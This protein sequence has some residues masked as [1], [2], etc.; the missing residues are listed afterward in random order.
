MA[1][2]AGRLA[3]DITMAKPVAVAVVVVVIS[4]LGLG[5][6]AWGESPP[7]RVKYQSNPLLA[8]ET[9]TPKVLLVLSKE[10]KMFGQG[11]PGLT[12][13]DGDGRVD[14][15]FN[16]LVEYV[17]YFDSRSCYA[18]K[19][20]TQAGVNGVFM[21]GDRN[22]YFVRVGDTI[23]DQSEQAIKNSRPRGLKSYVISPRSVAGVCSNLSRSVTY[24]GQ[25]TFSGNWLNH[26]AASRMDAIRRVLYGG[27]RKVDTAFRTVLEHSFVPPDANAWGA[28]VRSDDTWLMVTPNSAYYDIRKYSPY[29][30][31]KSGTSHFF[32]RSSDLGRGNEYFPAM[33]VLLD[34]TGSY[35]NVKGKDSVNM[36]VAHT[37]P[38]PRYWDWV[39]VNRPLPDDMVLTQSARKKVLVYNLSVE[40]CVKNDFSAT[41]GCQAY[42][43]LTGTPAGEVYKPVG[44]LQRY[45]GGGKPIN[46]G[47]LTGGYNS[48]IRDAGGKLR[49][50]V[51]PVNGLPG[52]PN[53]Q[54]VPP[55]NTMTGQ[56][57]K[58][59]II[60]NIDNLRISGRPT[61]KDPASWDGQRYYNV[62]SWGNPVAEMLFE[63]VRYL[64]GLNNPSYEY[65]RQ[66]DTDEA[67]SPI[68][69]LTDF[70]SGGSAWAQRR[71]DLGNTRCSKSI[72][73]LISDPTTEKDGDQFQNDL[74]LNLMP[75]ITLPGHFSEAN[76]LPKKFDK[77]VY[78][79]TI[80]KIEG[81]NGQ[82]NYIYS[83][84]AT[85]TC[86]PKALWSLK[87]VK[88]QCPFSPSTE[89]TYAV[90][91]VAYYA[92]AHNFGSGQG[93][94]GTNLDVYTVTMS[95]PFPELVFKVKTPTGPVEKSVSILPAAISEH[96]SGSGKILN[97]LNYFVIDWDTDRWGLPFHVKIK[98]NFSDQIMGDDWEGDAQVTYEIDLLT[99]RNTP[100]AMR[101]N[102]VASI[103]SGERNVKLQA[104]YKFKNPAQADN[105][106]AFSEIKPSMVKAILIKTSYDKAGTYMGMAMGYTISGTVYDGTYM[107]VTLNTPPANKILTPPGCPYVFAYTTSYN[108]CG[109]AVKNLTS[110]SRVFALTGNRKVNSLPDPLWLAAKYGGFTDLNQNG[111][112]D[113]GEWEDA[114]GDPKNYFR[115]S[116][117]SELPRKLESAFQSMALSVS[118]GLAS[119]AS[120]SSALGGGLSIQ[121]YFYHVYSDSL[122]KSQTVNWVGGVY[123]LFLDRFGNLREDSDGDAKLTLKSDPVTGRGDN[124]VTFGSGKVTQNPPVC[125]APGQRISRCQDVTG[126]NDLALLPKNQ[127][128]PQSVHKISPLFDTAKWLASLDQ[129]KLLLGSRPYKVPAAMSDGR[130][131]I[132]YGQ[133]IGRG[134]GLSLRRFGV[135]ESLDYLTPL[136][137]SNNFD[138]ILPAGLGGNAKDRRRE[139]TKKL[140]EY[141]TG[142]DR[143]GFRAR[144]VPDPWG[145]NKT[146]TW[147]HGDVINSKPVLVNAPAY[148]Y[149]LAYQDESYANF[150][151]TMGQR[152]QVLYYGA[153]DGML[154]AVNLGFG[155]FLG[156]G[157]AAYQKTLTG[158]ETPHEIGAEMWAYIPTSV[159]PHLQWLADPQY[160]HADYVDM[161]PLIADVKDGQNWRTL[162][163]GG[164]RL[165]GRPIEAAQAHGPQGDHYFSEFFC[166]DVTDPEAEPKLLWRYST[167]KLGLSVGLPAV[168]K[169]DGKFYVILASGPVTDVPQIA[170]QVPWI[171]Y[172]QADPAEG[173]SNQNAR[174]IVLDALT[175]LEPVNTDPDTGGDETFLMAPEKN[176]FFNEPFVPM[177]QQ[178]SPDWNNHAVYY[179]LTVSRD[180]KDGFDRGAVYRLQM[181]NEAN[182]PL[183]VRDWKLKRLLN[184]D[185]PVSAA[186][187]SAKNDQGQLWVLFGTGRLWSYG[188][189]NPCLSNPTQACRDNHK[190]YLFGIKEPLNRDGFMTFADLTGRANQILDVSGA[191][192]FSDG[193]VKNLISQGA[194]LNAYNGTASYQTVKLAA[195]SSKTIGYKRSLEMEKL[196]NPTHKHPSEMIL[197][198]P[199]IIAQGRGQSLMA[200]TSFEPSGEDCGS[201]GQGFQYA[202]DTFTGLPD[203]INKKAFPLAQN[204]QLPKDVVTGAL[205]LGPGKPSEAVIL[206]FESKAIVRT[207]TSDGGVYDI[208]I[209]T[210]K[211]D[212]PSGLTSWREVMDLGLEL[213]PEA[214]TLDL[215]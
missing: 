142:V 27:K 21:V 210:Q 91:A 32:A 109:K 92:R 129:D 200:F 135:Q 49:N 197:S 75:N 8:G 16:P 158:A 11:Y 73:L 46:F 163:I 65:N 55:V 168:V 4:L 179:G 111:V 61:N 71:P 130:R 38:F 147:R 5:D 78:L 118:T 68:G 155:N 128:H 88:G 51:G 31:P 195:A 10:L 29:E 145:S 181:V 43:G 152:R 99:D 144:S 207:S 67:G 124:V 17:G 206:S 69:Q 102:K 110:Q 2:F 193:S 89:G 162:L 15:G 182:A 146:V 39:L 160:V 211:D 215:P 62:F 170:N 192:V 35:F 174:L 74:S 100:L 194:L 201:F 156:S 22:G 139:T 57:N 137:L 6:W 132:Y 202:V 141:V 20:S 107:D 117:I 123:G 86:L 13:L 138:E 119:S 101:D 157:Q 176:S 97:V 159:L 30:K 169:S 82:N 212:A 153:N 120:V 199:K 87:D 116:N 108:G 77:N 50:H 136:M 189:L 105:V 42:P 24:G 37:Q 186:V 164:L 175:G 204:S 84:G 70:G 47:L 115:A 122:D 149:D 180:P 171:Q 41:E 80:S 213:T 140:I 131:L 93:Q 58:K 85:D 45:G 134:L 205:A 66:G 103:D 18:Y 198:Q 133:P 121:S 44:L 40:A 33:K 114:H 143:V 1:R 3:K 166:L 172:G 127:A 56:V 79:D 161:K 48:L 209:P 173:H 81:I 34:V 208:E 14:T 214:M 104:L 36:P 196:L 12:D 95:A 154:H 126:N 52:N 59:G 125:H 76:N 187:N 94:N 150:K 23:E 90:A 106:H 148:G 19:G 25:R 60:D 113:K 185:R 98:V 7:L 53:G 178:R 165:G 64:G 72:V 112:P 203:P 63:G 184:T 191:R 177:A 96:P 26:L 54:Y 83:K 28:E 151:K 183:K 167:L 9:P 190:Q 188:D